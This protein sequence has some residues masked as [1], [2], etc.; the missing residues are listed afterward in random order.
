MRT[1]KNLTFTCVNISRSLIF[2]K[3]KLSLEDL[4]MEELKSR[5]NQLLCFTIIV[6]QHKAI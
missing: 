5:L 6:I 2:Y 4:N 1:L 3:A